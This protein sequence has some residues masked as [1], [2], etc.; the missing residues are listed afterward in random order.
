MAGHIGEP[1]DDEI[2]SFV[3][4]YYVIWGNHSGVTNQNEFPVTKYV[5]I[6]IPR[7]LLDL[8]SLLNILN[9]NI[10]Y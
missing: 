6:R 9:K 4:H 10:N 3:H 1:N 5:T 7:R 2:G 8:V